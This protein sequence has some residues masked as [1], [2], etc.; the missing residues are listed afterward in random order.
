MFYLLHLVFCW[1]K[2]TLSWFDKEGSLLYTEASASHNHARLICMN[3]TDLATVKEPQGDRRRIPDLSEGNTVVVMLS[4]CLLAS[5]AVKCSQCPGAGTRQTARA[6][7][8]PEPRP[9][10]L[11]GSAH[12]G[13]CPGKDCLGS[14]RKKHHSLAGS[15]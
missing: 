1:S 3:R 4:F 15:F 10:G 9:A 6:G 11:T 7:N 12:C 8:L 13:G 5:S 2:S 14:R